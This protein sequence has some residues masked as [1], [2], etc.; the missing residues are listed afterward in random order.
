MP[1]SSV[2]LRKLRHQFVRQHDRVSHAT[3]PA[4]A[5]WDTVG[6][7]TGAVPCDVGLGHEGT[8]VTSVL[9]ATPWKPA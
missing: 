1:P 8:D 4:G 9:P 7:G 5:L 3:S 2:R 6:F